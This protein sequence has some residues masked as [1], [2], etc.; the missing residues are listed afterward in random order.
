VIEKFF[1]LYASAFI[2]FNP[3]YI[4]EVYEFPMTFYTE[5]GDS[6]SF[7]ERVFTENTKKLIAI[8]KELS[9]AGV[10][11]EIL[12]ENQLSGNLMLVSVVWS[13]QTAEGQEVYN[14][15]TRYLMKEIAGGLKIKAVFVVDETSKIAALRQ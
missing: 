6:V 15:T 9:V 1:E 12:S 4:S 8:Y 5:N 13:F 3:V 14:A 2:S 10:T 7:E 11:F